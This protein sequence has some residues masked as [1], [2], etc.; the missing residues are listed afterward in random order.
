MK[1][2]F[3]E[4]II[5]GIPYFGLKAAPHLWSLTDG[6]KNS[7]LGTLKVYR[8]LGYHHINFGERKFSVRVHKK[9]P[10]NHAS[11]TYSFL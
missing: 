6:G 9:Y 11:K 8:V 4:A 7:R 10:N 3:N 5:D 2:P 1:L